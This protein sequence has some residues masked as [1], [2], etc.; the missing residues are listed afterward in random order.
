MFKLF[1]VAAYLFPLNAFAGGYLACVNPNDEDDWGWAPPITAIEHARWGTGN[2]F[3]PINEKGTWINGD[4]YFN[5]RGHS[6]LIASVNIKNFDLNLVESFCNALKLQCQKLGEQYSSVF[7]K[8]NA[9]FAVNFPF[10]FGYISFSYYLGVR[11]S[12][13]FDTS[14]KNLRST[15]CPNMNYPDF[16]NDGGVFYIF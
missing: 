1:L 13:T 2:S 10:K 3:I 5:K 14:R 11:N 16:P 15:T 4:H 12:D 7:V 9:I 6:G 8:E